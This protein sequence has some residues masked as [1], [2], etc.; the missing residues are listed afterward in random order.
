MK[1]KKQTLAF[2]SIKI[3]KDQGMK[4]TIKHKIG[5]ALILLGMVALLIAFA[6]P[7]VPARSNPAKEEGIDISMVLDL[8]ESMLS[9]DFEPNR[10]EVARETIKSFVE[11]RS[12]DRLAFIVFAGSAYTKIPLTLDHNIVQ[13]SLS[14]VGTHSVNE[15]GTAI[16][17][18]ISVGVNRLKKS[19]ASS[20]VLILVTDGDNNAGAINPMTAADLAAEMAIK[21]YT[22]GVGTDETIIPTSN[23]FGQTQYQKLEGGLNE[24]LLQ[25]IADKT[26]GK[27]FR[28]KDKETLEHIFEDIDQLEKSSFDQNHFRKFDELAFGFIK[29]GLVFIMLGMFF[30][31][32]Y[33]IQ[34]P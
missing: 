34:I 32:Y 12:N 31:K 19:E 28:A 23:I 22:I 14:E 29:I 25:D 5:K 4:K 16:G 11:T 27:Y 20:K 2:S 6:R 13:E 10:L 24:V 8:S 9:I 3:L 7:Q 18:S 21:I 15:P 30:D 1:H 17:M 26:G 33:Y